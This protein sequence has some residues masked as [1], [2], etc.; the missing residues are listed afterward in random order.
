MPDEFNFIDRLRSVTDTTHPLVYASRNFQDDVAVIEPWGNAPQPYIVITKDMVSAGTHFFPTDPPELIIKKAIRVNISDLAAKGARPTWIA[1][2]AA[3]PAM[4]TQAKFEELTDRIAQGLKEDCKKYDIALIGGDTIR[5]NSMTFSVTAAGVSYPPPPSRSGAKPGDGIYVTG[6]ALGKAALGLGIK[7]NLYDLTHIPEIL[8]KKLLD[9]Y[10]LPDPDPNLGMALQAFMS[11]SCD[12][13]D[14]LLADLSNILSA[15]K[16]GA[17]IF[18]SLVPYEKAFYNHEIAL[19]AAFEGG[20]DYEILFTSSAE[21]EG[22]TKIAE[23]FGRS[24]TKI[25][26][27]TPEAECVILDQDNQT[28][29]DRFTANAAFK[30]F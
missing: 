9:F 24:V 20:D 29:T 3:L 17:R 25:G 13:S 7:K 27:I 11:A 8:Q 6:Q 2:G 4:K 10:H 21:A 15:S 14:G 16:T 26:E 1:V 18:S 23:H 12:L 22:L 5:A 30:H 19:K 28:R